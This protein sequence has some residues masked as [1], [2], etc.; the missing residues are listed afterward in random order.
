[1]SIAL[2]RI[3]A[4]LRCCAALAALLLAAGCSN[5]VSPNVSISQTGG[6]T[7]PVVQPAGDADDD[8]IGAREHPRIVA[9]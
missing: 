2:R 9:S 5:R 1:M 6:Q 4:G 7:A 3:V 8:A